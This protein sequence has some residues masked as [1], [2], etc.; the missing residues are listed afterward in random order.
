MATY[1]LRPNADWNNASA[2]TIVGGAGSAYASLADNSDATYITRTSTTVPASYEMELGTTTL[3]SNEKIATVNLRAKFNVGTSGIVQ[4]SLG[5]ITDRNGKI[6]YYSVPY[7]KQKTFASATVD[8]SL[9]LTS[10]PNG[11][12]WTQT[13]LD[14]LVVKWT[15]GATASADRGQLL[16]VYADVVTTAQPTVTVTSPTG[17]VTTTSFVSI[18]WTYADADG[19]AQ[20]AY[21]IKV[22][23]STTYGGSSFS[24]DTSTPIVETGIITSN[25]AGQTLEVSLP[26]STTYRAYVRVAQLLNGVNYFSSWAYSQ[27]TMGID[28]PA[29]PTIV[30]SYDSVTNSVAITVFGRT[31]VLS[32]NQASFE[33]DTT[34]WTTVSNST[35]ARSTAQ[36][37]SGTASLSMTSVASGDM[38]ASTT[39]ATKELV[40]ANQSFSATAEFFAASVVRSC[41]VGII[42]LDSAGTAISTAYGTASVN[43]TS[44]WSQKT[45]TATAPSTAVYAQ[46]IVKVISTGGASEVHYVDK[47]SFHAGSSP[48]W[49]RGGFSNFIFDVERSD[50]S[51]VT[52]TTVRNSPVTATVAQIAQLNDYENPLENTSYYRAKARADI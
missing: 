7:T 45:I 27:F 22:F 12:E 48:T 41:A 51:Q 15:D 26:N 30:A 23:D 4:L 2:F 47:V 13:L 17:T 19:D 43:S 24:A 20:N 21:E 37:S 14:N 10:A 42:W 36:A 38:T 5:V 11:A 16:E 3:A 28:A 50:D 40:T 18:N 25:N 39:T 44:A 9:Y 52:W 35:I 34:G 29:V 33:T 8:M 32:D 31:N 46:V 6:V 1:T 49:T